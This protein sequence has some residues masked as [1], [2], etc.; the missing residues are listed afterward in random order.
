METFAIQKLP[1]LCEECKKSLFFLKPRIHLSFF[2]FVFKRCS[3]LLFLRYL[4]PVCALQAESADILNLYMRAFVWRDPKQVKEVLIKMENGFP[5][6]CQFMD[7]KIL[8]TDGVKWVKMCK[9]QIWC[10]HSGRESHLYVCEWFDLIRFWNDFSFYRTQ[11]KTGKM[12]NISERKSF[13]KT[14]ILLITHVHYLRFVQISVFLCLILFPILF[15]YIWH[16]SLCASE[17]PCSILK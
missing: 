2:V 14:T 9:C 17:D 3:S 8:T 15:F 10:F 1:K 11:R 12:F 16:Y 7:Y 5:S 4:P 13:F 6:L